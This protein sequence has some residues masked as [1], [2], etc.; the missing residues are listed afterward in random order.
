MDSQMFE[1]GKGRIFVSGL[2]WQPLPGATTSARKNEILK[3]ADEQ[4]FDLAVIRTTGAPQVGFGSVS[5]GVRAGMLSAAAMISKTV[6]VD[7]GDRNFLCA[8]EVSRDQW[9]YVAQREGVLLSDGDILG[10]EDTIRARLLTDMSLSDWETIFAPGHWGINGAI[11]KSFDDFLPKKGG[12]LDYKRWWGV[13]PVKT[14][15]RDLFRAYWPLVVLV[16]VGLGG[17]YGHSWWLQHKAEQEMAQISADQ[18]VHASVDNAPAKPVHPW[19]K[20][21]RATKALTEC[22]TALSK[23]KTLWP[24]NW[25][26]RDATCSNGSL[27]VVW[28]RQDYGWI[29]H[30]RAVEPNAVISNDG[31]TASLTVPMIVPEGEDETLPTE[32]ERSL[33]LF[34]AAQ[35]YGFKLNLSAPVAPAALPGDKPNSPQAAQDWRGV[36]WSVQGSPLAPSVILPTMEGNGF[37]VSR[38]QAVWSGGVM[39]WSMEGIQYVQP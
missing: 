34:S 10:T 4:K 25:T 11:E 33:A 31:S 2:F 39:I 14:G 32:R 17:A 13:K 12:R 5:D 6:E 1:Y 30:L 15:W 28:L 38:I 3:I 35:R 22:N 16:V 7:G 8:T 20:T 37:R 18:A 26:L 19:K 21:P 27:I 29:E 36:A 23:V 24:G 9:L